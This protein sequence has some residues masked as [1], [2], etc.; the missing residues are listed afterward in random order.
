MS[1][2][3]TRIHIRINPDQDDKLSKIMERYGFRSRYQIAKA[4][5]SVF[6]ANCDISDDTNVTDEISEM[7]NEL[8][9]A[10]AIEYVRPQRSLPHVQTSKT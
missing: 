6:I 5:L 7:F 8:E 3:N 9:N 1:K 2:N 10:E 4:V